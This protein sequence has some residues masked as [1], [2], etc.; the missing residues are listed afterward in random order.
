MPFDKHWFEVAKTVF[1]LELKHPLIKN[2]FYLPINS[3]FDFIKLKNNNYLPNL[4]EK[5]L[6]NSISD[7]I[8][9]PFM[10]YD[11]LCITNKEFNQFD[12]ELLPYCNYDSTITKH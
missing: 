3:D 9:K 5:L 6:A 11:K 10:A 8:G 2:L 1:N 7:V 12:L 4:N